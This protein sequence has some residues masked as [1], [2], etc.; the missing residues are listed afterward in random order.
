MVA[1]A[2]LAAAVLNVEVPEVLMVLVRQNPTPHHDQI[3]SYSLT[4][5]YDAKTAT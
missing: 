2:A 1:A 3:R 5:R 4:M